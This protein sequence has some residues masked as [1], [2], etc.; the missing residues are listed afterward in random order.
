MQIPDCVGHCGNRSAEKKTR[1]SGKSG[2][3]LLELCDQAMQVLISAARGP[4]CFLAL[5]GNLSDVDASMTTCGAAF[6]HTIRTTRLGLSGEMYAEACSRPGCLNSGGAAPHSRSYWG[7]RT[8]RGN[9]TLRGFEKKGESV[10]GKGTE[11]ISRRSP[12]EKRKREE[13]ERN[14]QLDP[15]HGSCNS[16]VQEADSF[17]CILSSDQGLTL[18]I[19]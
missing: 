6:K 5:P 16:Y 12:G 2:F 3:C 13:K 1:G 15:A 18:R 7:T 14:R 11:K 4:A 10:K 19:Q 17:P 8:L 9:S